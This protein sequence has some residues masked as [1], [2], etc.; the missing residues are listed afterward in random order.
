MGNWWAGKWW[1]MH[2]GNALWSLYKT[3]DKATENLLTIGLKPL[4]PRQLNIDTL[5][6]CSISDGILL[7]ILFIFRYIS[8]GPLIS[9]HVFRNSSTAH[10][11]AYFGSM[12]ADLLF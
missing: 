6:S 3:F 12:K 7:F 5:P 9:A 2:V 1:E 4:I 10:A 8:P 11:L